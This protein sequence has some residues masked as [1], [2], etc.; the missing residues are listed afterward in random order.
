MKG[1][2]LK[3]KCMDLVLIFSLTEQSIKETGKPT[4][5]VGMGYMNFPMARSTKVNFKTIKCM[6]QASI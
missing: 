5:S 1:N 2:G 3:I 4:N 6:E